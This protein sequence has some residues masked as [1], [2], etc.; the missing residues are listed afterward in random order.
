MSLNNFVIF[1]RLTLLSIF[2]QFQS[3]FYCGDTSPLVIFFKYF[4]V[5]VILKFASNSVYHL[6]LS[7]KNHIHANIHPHR[8]LCNFKIKNF[9]LTLKTMIAPHMQ[10][11]L[12]V[13]DLVLETV[14]K[15]QH[16][17]QTVSH[18]LF[19]LCPECLS[20]CG[21]DMYAS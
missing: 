11:L 20:P 13:V 5:F 7:K 18:A 17:A 6:L 9:S 21:S 19:C 10:F 2:L 3:T 16:R 14:P 4:I 12:F 15:S 1:F 8:P